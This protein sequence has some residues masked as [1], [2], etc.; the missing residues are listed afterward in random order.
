ML[1]AG[2]YKVITSQRPKPSYTINSYQLR[3]IPLA[4]MGARG[5]I[6]KTNILDIWLF[7][8]YP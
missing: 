2:S 7:Y 6:Q 5:V 4:G 8:D 3:C 1:I